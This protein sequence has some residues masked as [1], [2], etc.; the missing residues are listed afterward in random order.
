MH[1]EVVSRIQDTRL[2]FLAQVQLTYLVASNR[3]PVHDSGLISIYSTESH[4]T[5]KLF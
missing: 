1:L 5:F 2:F 3:C 4:N